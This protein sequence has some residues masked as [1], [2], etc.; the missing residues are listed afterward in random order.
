MSCLW[1]RNCAFQHASSGGGEASS[2]F[3]HRHLLAQPRMASAAR[4]DRQGLKSAVQMLINAVITLAI[5]PRA[6]LLN[7]LAFATTS[8]RESPLQYWNRPCLRDKT[9]QLVVQRNGF[10]WPRAERK[11]GCRPAAQVRALLEIA[12]W[13]LLHVLRSVVSGE[14][15]GYA[16]FRLHI[17]GQGHP[18]WLAGRAPCLNVTLRRSC[19]TSPE[20][21]RRRTDRPTRPDRCSC[22]FPAS[23]RT[24]C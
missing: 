22:R 2:C 12:S 20:R 6:Y 3:A 5:E 8:D 21:Q 14:P 15:R 18:P 23:G 16:H 17:S 24:G 9:S 1:S 4:A 11:V 7:R 19:R 10:G 13:T